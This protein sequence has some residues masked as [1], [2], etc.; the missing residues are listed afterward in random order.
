VR[1]ERGAQR[2]CEPTFSARYPV[3]VWRRRLAIGALCAIALAGCGG[4][5]SASTTTTT[6]RTASFT[7]GPTP[8]TSARMICRHE[9]VAA[10]ASQ[11]VGVPTR[12][13]PV[14]TWSHHRYTCTYRYAN[15][16]MVLW[17]QALPSLAATSAYT[18]G[19]ARARGIAQRYPN[20]GRSAFE[21]TDGSAVSRKDNKVLVVDVGGLPANFGKP[22]VA[23]GDIALSVTEL[24]LACWRGD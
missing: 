23:R 3:E 2:C 1:D 11:S 20:V 6:T 19:L 5:P 7:Y 24:I 21:T 12:S 16:T 13:T 8:S 17:V 9:T 14:A 4:T 18:A 15:G 10:I 22:P